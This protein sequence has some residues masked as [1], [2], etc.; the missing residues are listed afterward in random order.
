MDESNKRLP[1]C[2]DIPSQS[3][4]EDTDF[5]IITHVIVSTYVHTIMG[6]IMRFELRIWNATK[7]E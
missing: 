7:S 4:A 2:R 5:M 1:K 6:K 3:R